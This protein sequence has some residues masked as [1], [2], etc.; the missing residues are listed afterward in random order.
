M[1][2][3]SL[4]KKGLLRGAL[5]FLTLLFVT[6]PG[7]ADENIRVRA[8]LE[9]CCDEPEPGAEGKSERKTDF[10]EGVMVRDRFK[11]ML[12]IPIP[13][14]GLGILTAEEAAAAE[15]RVTLSRDGV[16]YAE[17]TLAFAADEEEEEGDKAHFAVDIDLKVKK[18]VPVLNEKKGS[19]DTDLATND[20]Q[21]G[22]P[23]VL[24]GDVITATLAGTGVC[25]SWRE[26][27]R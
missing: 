14:E 19:C 16:A 24:E 25:R 23:D 6:A 5:A 1:S 10:K 7:V 20:V 22:V 26:P 13:S 2:C 4:W 11:A 3:K 12:D 8:E 17:C 18:E 21:A 15:V 9:P 27:S